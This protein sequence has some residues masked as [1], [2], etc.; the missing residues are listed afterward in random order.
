MFHTNRR[1]RSRSLGR[2]CEGNPTLQIHGSSKAKLLWYYSQDIISQNPTLFLTELR[3]HLHAVPFIPRL[4]LVVLGHVCAGKTSLLRSLQQLV[5]GEKSGPQDM[6]SPVAINNIRL[7]L[8]SK[9][10]FTVCDLGGQIEYL[11][12]YQVPRK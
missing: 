5:A 9:L 3:A 2:R 10:E 8:H 12:A 1:A 6:T 7:R 11:T 4:K